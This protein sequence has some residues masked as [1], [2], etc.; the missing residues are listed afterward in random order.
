MKRALSRCLGALF[1]GAFFV[2]ATAQTV[3]TWSGFGTGW[4]GQVTPPNDGT[5]IFYLPKAINETIA[6][7]GSTVNLDAIL[8]APGSS[9]DTYAFTA[10]APLTLTLGTG[11]VSTGTGS[12]RLEFA[13]NINITGA[14][15]LAFDAGNSSIVIP[16]QINGS[17]ALGLV[18][19]NAANTNGAFIF[20]NT[21]VAGNTYTGGTTISGVTGSTVATAFWNSSPFGTGAVNVFSSAQFI[22][23]NTLTVTN[24][25]T[26]ST[27]TANDPIY[28]K[29]WD[30][31]LTLS[32]AITL[33]NN[34][35]LFAQASQHG[36]PSADNSGIYPTPGPA[37]RNPIIFTGAIG[38]TS[39]HSLTVNGGGVLILNPSGTNTYTG[40][41]SVNGSLVFANNSVIP[42]TGTIMVNNGGY[43]GIAN[44]TPGNFATFL[45]R[46]NTSSSLGAVGVDTLPGGSTTVLTDNINLTG[47]TNPSIRIGTA[48]SAI[49]QGGIIPQGV[50]YQFGNGGGYLDVQSS[51]ADVSTPSSVQ[52]TD[53]NNS[54]LLPPLKLFLQGTNS[55]T[56][57]TVANNG[58]I[59]FDAFYSLPISG[60]LTAAGSSTTNGASYIGYTDLVSG[61]TPTSFLAQFNKPNTWGIIGFDTNVHS[62][63]TATISGNINLTGFNNGVY[64]GTATSAILSG[65]LT[66]T[67]DNILRL[68]AANGGT[69]TVNSTITG[70][71][72]LALGT[73]SIAWAYSDGTV[74]LNGA[75]TYTGGTTINSIGSGITVQAG[76][77]V[78]LGTGTVT[79]P[80]NVNAGLQASTSSIILPNSI[81][82]GAPVTSTDSA[83]SLYI[84]GSNAFELSGSISGPG[85]LNLLT[86]LTLS[87]NNSSFTGDINFI[88]NTTLNLNNNNAAGTGTVRFNKTTSSINFG[89][90][91]LNPILYGISGDRGNVNLNTGMVLTFDTTNLINDNNFGGIVGNA[92]PVNASLVITASSGDNA[93]YLYGN[94]NYTGGTT[95]TN[96]GFVGLGHNNA[97]GTGMVTLNAPHGAIALNEGI[98][99]SNPLTFTAGALMGYGTFTPSNLTSTGITIGANQAVIPGLYSSATSKNNVPGNLTLGTNTIF[100]TGGS[101]FWSLQDVSRSDG[102]SG[103]FINGNLD[104]TTISTGG[105]TIDMLTFDATDHL[106]L[107]NLVIGSPYTFTIL[108]TTGTIAGFNA[109]DFTFNT[110]KFENGLASFP[111]LSLTAD[112]QHL[113]LTFT[114]VPEP[115]TWALLATGAG[116]LGLAAFRRRR[117]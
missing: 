44:T 9:N 105:F 54:G 58:F 49:L 18:N 5:A 91:A 113:F 30:A 70:G 99:F 24:A 6:L 106:G 102:H 10:A 47:F 103:L 32:G 43:A 1:F 13:P 61:T 52:L 109:A 60:Q 42:A 62:T 16:G 80:Q 79:L 28:F 37:S 56:G 45:S 108:T 78:A 87:G 63:S 3:F 93:L 117:A 85:S 23:H 101:Y 38:E 64:L 96:Y 55:Y 81:V 36:V 69:L 66:P 74:I 86:P 72:A 59:I 104:L 88:G 25:F 26:F 75:N 83:A 50:N 7:S 68:T 35:T 12:S 57:G 112:S 107:A 11:I 76:S 39:S 40:G 65:T 82:F 15:T 92:A 77:S 90:A 115:S 100:A 29:S 94:N 110:S 21:G 51:L 22:A 33:G 97:L 14:T 19:S 53:A 116:L 8:F 89:A 48:T 67:A 2:S 95:I 20:N 34:T 46:V 71:T 27:V 31:P 111:I 98:T 41:T 84:T 17:V 4:Q 114:A 73:P